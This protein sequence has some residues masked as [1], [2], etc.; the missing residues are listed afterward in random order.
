MMTD[1]RFLQSLLDFD[2]DGLKDKQAKQV[3]GL[4][5]YA[6]PSPPSTP[7]RPPIHSSEPSRSRWDGSCRTVESI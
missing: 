6:T 1:G 4:C 3:C 2:K 5:E 7:R